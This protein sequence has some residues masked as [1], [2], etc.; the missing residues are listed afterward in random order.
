M[1]KIKETN[2]GDSDTMKKSLQMGV[3][4][5]ILMLLLCSCHEKKQSE[6]EEPAASEQQEGIQ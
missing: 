2:R 6:K 1:I 5:V 4:T 3:L